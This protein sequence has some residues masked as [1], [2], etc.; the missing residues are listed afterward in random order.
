MRQ[1]LPLL[2]SVLALTGCV[3]RYTEP[4]ITDP[5]A[6][7]RVRVVRHTW[8]GPELDES[9]RLNGYAIELGPAGPGPSTRA[10]RVRPEPTEWRFST[11]FFHRV[12][13]PVTRYVTERYACGSTR[14]GF[15]TTSYTSTQYCS[16]TVPRTDYITER[17]VDAAC[18]QLGAHVPLPGAAYIIQYDFF[19]HG[20]CTMRCLRQLPAP[21]GSFTLVPCGRGEPLAAPPIV[22]VTARPLQTAG[23]PR[24]SQELGAP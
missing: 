20:R 2:L 6:I 1:L 14:S 11:T 22:Q 3:R 18:G 19:A 13:R 5:H 21:G 24:P 10:L 9:V 23:E 4:A 7:V 16:R 15:G 12:T 17:V 8:A